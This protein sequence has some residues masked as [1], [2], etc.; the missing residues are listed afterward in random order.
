[1]RA[2]LVPILGPDRISRMFIGLRRFHTNGPPPLRFVRINGSPGAVTC[3]S[4]GNINVMTFALENGRV[5]A[6]YIVRNPDKLTRVKMGD[7]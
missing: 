7:P 2:A 5:K 6:V 4:D 3:G 1:M